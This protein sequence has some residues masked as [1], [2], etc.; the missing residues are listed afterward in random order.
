MPKSKRNRIV[1]TSKV[2]KKGKDVS[3]KLFAAVQESADAYQHCFVFGVEN[4]RNTYLKEI[5]S[6]FAGTRY[7]E[8]DFGR[9]CS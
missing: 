2:E 9:R 7:V 8:P 1:P 3:L 6:A 4:M 5:R